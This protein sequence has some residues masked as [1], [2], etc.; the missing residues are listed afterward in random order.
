MNPSGSDVA[1]ATILTNPYTVNLDSTAFPSRIH[2]G[3]I[4]NSNRDRRHVVVFIRLVDVVE[5][6]Q[7]HPEMN[8]FK[9]TELVQISRYRFYVD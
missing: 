7:D 2:T 6:I 3:T 5:R 1:F 9:V 4:C 8:S